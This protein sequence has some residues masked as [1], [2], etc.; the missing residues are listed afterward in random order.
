MQKI[1]PYL[2]GQEISS[3]TKGNKL[4][5]G[6][7]AKRVREGK[8]ERVAVNES[9]K[10][11][12]LSELT[13]IKLTGRKLHE[14]V[15]D[16]INAFI[17]RLDP[18][19]VK[20]MP[21]NDK[22]KLYSAA[23]EAVGDDAKGN[24][25]EI[26]TY[27]DGA[28]LASK[29][30]NG[31]DS[32]SGVVQKYMKEKRD[33][34]G[35]RLQEVSAGFDQSDGSALHEFSR[36]NVDLDSSSDAFYQAHDGDTD[37]HLS[38]DDFDSKADYVEELLAQGKTSSEV[39]TLLLETSNFDYDDAV[40]LVESISGEFLDESG[41]DEPADEYD[42]SPDDPDYV[43]EDYTGN[44][45]IEGEFNEAL[46]DFDTSNDRYDEKALFEHICTR[47]KIDG[48]TGKE[49]L[50]ESGNVFDAI[51]AISTRV[52]ESRRFREAKPSNFMKGAILAGITPKQGKTKA[53]EDVIYYLKS[54]IDNKYSSA[55][56]KT[57]LDRIQ[58][59]LRNEVVQ[60]ENGA[61]TDT[62]VF[63]R[64]LEKVAGDTR[65]LDTITGKQGKL[66][67]IPVI[68]GVVKKVATWIPKTSKATAI[69]N[70]GLAPKGLGKAQVYNSL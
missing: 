30:K 45:D 11:I 39:V 59:V 7:I 37:L 6:Y 43:D 20:Q 47:F 38:E 29:V 67:E 15:E 69:V 53:G 57:A 63:M 25:D 16:G 27:I 12:R 22:E 28:L 26:K 5:E 65:Y 61:Q 40:S 42:F 46:D 60:D 64:E 1:S 44:D 4:F 21:D 51:V 34:I 70:S 31:T 48:D 49:V 41:E 50:R 23:E 2:T 8:V 13:N 35:K 52:R 14:D 3:Y 68:Q 55:N 36:E 32:D 19:K 62:M 66:I 56:M 10:W 24:E 58:N 54:D 33:T 9:G 17:D 18:D